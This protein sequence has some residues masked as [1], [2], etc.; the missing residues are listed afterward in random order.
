MNFVVLDRL[1]SA[2][3]RRYE[4]EDLVAVLENQ[5]RSHPSS[6]S[7]D[8]SATASSSATL[9]DN[10]ALRD[11]VQ[12]L[13]RKVS[14]LEDVMQENHAK[15]EREENIIRE[16]LRRYK[17][18]EESIKKELEDGRTELDKAV[19]AEDTLKGRVQELEEALRESTVALENAQA[20]IEGLRGDLANYE[21]LD[22]DSPDKSLDHAQ[23]GLNERA[24]LHEEIT[25]L[26]QELDDAR[27]E[28]LP[29]DFLPDNRQLATD[30]TFQA[31]LLIER[32]NTQE[33][34]QLAEQRMVE[35]ETLRK[36]LN[37]DLPL[38][39]GRGDPSSSSSSKHDSSASRQEITGLKHIVQELQKDN[40]AIVQQNKVL[41]AENKLLLSETEKLREEIR[42]LEDNFE[43]SLL[44]EERELNL[45]D[46]VLSSSDASSLQRALNELR[47]KQEVELEQLRKRHADAEMKS[48]R[49]I[50]DLNKE[51]SELETLVESKIYRED[52]LEREVDRLKDKLSRGQKKS[53]KSSI[54]PGEARLRVVSDQGP[55]PSIQGDVCEICE[56]PGHDIFSCD[57]LKEE[58]P[59]KLQPLKI[60]VTDPSEMYCED[61]ETHGHL[62]K[63]CPHSLDVF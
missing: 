2:D 46:S 52:E 27:K 29:A 22:D 63:D 37:R 17:E 35:L 7:D 12:Y 43:Q 16:K 11:Q 1:S 61:C 34:R 8:A 51:V 23:R 18:K 21:G 32:A 59:K 56:R 60:N 28:R 39:N 33:F 55:P 53:S 3:A 25:R 62:S 5:L 20:E 19:R 26:K 58:V 13:Q 30:E 49:V 44:R 31:Q 6:R 41:T 15:S 50:H 57:L 4:M 48:A 40:L 36:K 10:E 42:S 9:I 14:N 24:R 38:S 45:G 47:A 54:D